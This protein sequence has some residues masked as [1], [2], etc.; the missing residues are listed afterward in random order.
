VAGSGFPAS[1]IERALGGGFEVAGHFHPGLRYAA[2]G[3]EVAELHGRPV[4]VHGRSVNEIVIFSVS[5]RFVVSILGEENFILF[6]NQPL[7]E[8]KPGTSL[9]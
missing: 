1:F 6:R 7:D 3:F 8:T 4:T 2:E 5:F 9:F